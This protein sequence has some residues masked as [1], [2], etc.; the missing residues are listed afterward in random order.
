MYNIKY[1]KYRIEQ[2]EGEEEEEKRRVALTGPYKAIDHTSEMN[3]VLPS[4]R[5]TRSRYYLM[6][7]Y[8]LDRRMHSFTSL[9]VHWIT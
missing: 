1:S 3:L 8:T 9:C 5:T 6:A 2:E 7:D 4:A